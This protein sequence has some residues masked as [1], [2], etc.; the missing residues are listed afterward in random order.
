MKQQRTDGYSI[1]QSSSLLKHVLLGLIVFLGLSCLYFGSFLA[2]CD[3]DDAIDPV[4]S[5]FVHNPDAIEQDNS[6]IQ[7]LDSL[8]PKTISICDMKYSE[9]IPCLDRNLT[10]MEHYERHCPP[11]EQRFNCLT[12]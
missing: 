12:K 5:S 11:S 1:C 10:L 2:P 8:L 9:L 3:A 7:N 6:H 4:F